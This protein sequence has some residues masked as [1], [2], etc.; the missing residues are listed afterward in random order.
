MTTTEEQIT[1]DNSKIETCETENTA[2]ISNSNEPDVNK[3]EAVKKADNLNEIEIPQKFKNQDGSTNIQA[4]VKSYKELEPL[5]NEK[6]TW[7]KEKE[8][9]TSKLSKFEAKNATN[10]FSTLNADFFE[11][12]IEQSTDKEKAK[13]LI[14]N[15][16]KTNST[17][18]M[19]ELEKLYPLETVK[20]AYFNATEIEKGINQNWLQQVQATEENNVKDYLKDVVEKHFEELKNPVTAE[21]FNEAFLQFGS[22]FDADWFFGKMQQLKESFILNYQKEQNIKKETKSAITTA[23]KIAPKSSTN[24]GESLLNRNALDLSPQELDKML[25]EYYSM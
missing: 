6:A 20:E 19:K 7:G 1:S 23:S 14:E 11:K 16:R 13:E 8:A 24:G 18:T 12:E 2:Q 9:L 17:E 21:I 5:I 15:F 3:N 4:L 25:D 10:A 22:N